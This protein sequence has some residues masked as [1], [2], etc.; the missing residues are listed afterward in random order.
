MVVIGVLCWV[1]ALGLLWRL[2]WHRLGKGLVV[3]GLGVVG[4]LFVGAGAASP[5]PQTAPARATP[6]SS[7]SPALSSGTAKAA[8]P[9]PQWVTVA[10]WQGD[11]AGRSAPFTVGSTWRVQ[12]EAR[13]GPHGAGNFV[14]YVYRVGSQVPVGVIGNVIGRGHDISYQNGA[15]TYYLDINA[16]EPYTIGVAT[17]APAPGQPHYQWSNVATFSGA[18]VTTTAPFTVQAPW[19]VVWQTQSGSAGST[20]FQ[21]A[22]QAAGETVPVDLFANVIGTDQGVAYEYR[23]GTFQLSINAAQPYRLVVQTGH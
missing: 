8:A 12:W 19:R 1:A 7:A 22:V 15:G 18:D 17:P 20:N 4:V 11:S 21:V 3:A 5:M 13:P 2:R 6:H 23:S 14:L 16:D 9:S 10:Q